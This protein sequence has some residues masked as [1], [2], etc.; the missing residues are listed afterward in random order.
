MT[1]NIEEKQFEEE[2]LS[3]DR[4]TR[5]V[6]GGRRLR[7]RAIVVVGDKK[8]KI[9]LGTGKSNEVVGAVQKATRK[10]KQNLI[11]VPI[12]NDTIP[13]D[14]TIKYKSAKILLMPAGS[15]T[16][17]IAGSV[18]R[19]ILA[20]AG[21]KNILSK[22]FGSSNKLL[23]AQATLLAL[24]QLK[25]RKIQKKEEKKINISPKK[26]EGSEKT[27]QPEK[28]ATTKEQKDTQSHKK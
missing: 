12:W 23:N 17:I 20:L 18:V 24:Q 19:K 26:K 8:G 4:V 25:E 1:K 3:I 16:G 27:K 11:T 13:H 5:V 9:G 21:Y 10:A 28:P 6:A 2:V 22:I 15:G 7:F 14:I